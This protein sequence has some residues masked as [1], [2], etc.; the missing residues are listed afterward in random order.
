LTNTDGVVTT[1]GYDGRNLRVT[2]AS[3]GTTTVYI[4]SGGK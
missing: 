4:F 1:Y 3:G 2:K